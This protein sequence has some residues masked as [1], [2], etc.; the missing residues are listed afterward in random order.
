M[1]AVEYIYTV[2]VGYQRMN[3]AYLQNFH[4]F[5]HPN[6]SAL[7]LGLYIILRK[8]NINVLAVFKSN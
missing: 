4:S 8:L 1:Q 3:L 5:Y 6:W 2:Y 7:C